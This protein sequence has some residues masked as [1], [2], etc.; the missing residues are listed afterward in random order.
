MYSALPY[1]AVYGSWTDR[2]HGPCTVVYTV[3]TRTALVMY[4]EVGSMGVGVGLYMY[5][6]VVKKVYVPYL[7]S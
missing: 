7:I 1:T 6:V 5:D 3:C 4:P 2:L